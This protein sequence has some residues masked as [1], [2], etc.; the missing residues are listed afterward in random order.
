VLQSPVARLCTELFAE[1]VTG[2][3]KGATG[4]FLFAKPE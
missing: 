1:I 2:E 4:M 3:N